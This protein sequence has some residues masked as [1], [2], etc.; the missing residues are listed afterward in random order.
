VQG[1][2]NGEDEMDDFDI[3]VQCEECYSDDFED[4]L[5]EIYV[6]GGDPDDGHVQKDQQLMARVAMVQ[7][8]LEVLWRKLED[9]GIY[10]GAN[11]IYLAQRLIE[12]L[13]SVTPQSWYP[14]E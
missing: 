8:R 9:D 3:Q 5:R 6:D 12:D 13:T 11:T 10:V 2:E 4:C 7:D 14:Q 1:L